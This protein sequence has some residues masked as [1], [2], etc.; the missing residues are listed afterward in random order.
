MP[1][2]VEQHSLATPKATPVSLAPLMENEPRQALQ[3][4]SLQAVHLATEL[5]PAVSAPPPESLLRKVVH[6]VTEGTATVAISTARCA[7]GSEIGSTMGGELAS[8]QI[9]E[10]AR[11]VGQAVGG[12]LGGASGALVGMATS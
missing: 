1:A 3:Q 8:Q 4:R 6:R 12:V 9:G 11:P 2:G 5:V 7:I 10:I